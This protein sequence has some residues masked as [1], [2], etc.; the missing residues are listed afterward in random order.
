MFSLFTNNLNR[1]KN[2]LK[3]YPKCDNILYINGCHPDKLKFELPNHAGI[4]GVLLKNDKELWG[5]C[6]Y[7]G[8]DFTPWEA[9]YFALIIGLEK[10]LADN[11]FMLTVCGDNL[12]VI[13]QINNVS[14]IESGLLLPLY[15]KLNTLKSKFEYIDF[16]YINPEDNKRARELSSLAIKNL[17]P[18]EN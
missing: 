13:N 11:I 18:F 4:G 3:V 17:N 10:V 9:E 1:K 5:Y 7:L 6:R 2:K 16:N 14:K 8:Y 15:K 12:D